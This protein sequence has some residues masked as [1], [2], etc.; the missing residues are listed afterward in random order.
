MGE[1]NVVYVVLAA[2]PALVYSGREEDH[3]A[4][5]VIKVGKSA[6]A[7]SR[8]I[9]EHKRA[10]LVVAKTLG[11]IRRP[12]E[13]VH[14]CETALKAALSKYNLRVGLL[15]D[16]G[17]FREQKECYS[18]DPKMLKAALEFMKTYDD[19]EA[20]DMKSDP[21]DGYCELFPEH[22][23]GAAALEVSDSLTKE[24]CGVLREYNPAMVKPGDVASKSARAILEKY[25]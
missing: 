17:D 23:D 25:R 18:A 1:K 19:W 24:E 7:L 13:G 16:T 5:I 22:E 4:P 21:L 2:C 8:R 20:F 15:T 10:G 9:Q 14:N 12:P 6:G 3:T 11:V